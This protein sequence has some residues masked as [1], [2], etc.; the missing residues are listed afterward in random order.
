MVACFGGKFYP[1]QKIIAEAGTVCKFVEG[2]FAVGFE[3]FE[4]VGTD[5]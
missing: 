2:G 1:A 5:E 4:T 3:G